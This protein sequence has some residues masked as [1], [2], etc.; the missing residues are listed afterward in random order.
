MSRP[1]VVLRMRVRWARWVVGRVRRG[2]REGL[3]G[4]EGVREVDFSEGGEEEEGGGGV[5]C[6]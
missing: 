3:D 4:G 1:G 5:E 2:E 6:G